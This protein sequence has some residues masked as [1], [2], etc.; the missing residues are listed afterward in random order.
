[1]ILVVLF[2]TKGIFHHEFVPRGQ[3]VNKPLYQKG[4]LHLSDSLSRK[5]PEMWENQARMLH[6]GNVPAVASLLVCVH[7]KYSLPPG[8]AP[9]AVNNDN[10]IIIIIIIITLNPNHYDSH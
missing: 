9:I 3:M 8:E 10:D 1:V 7:V 5:R 4:V 6:R 2:Y